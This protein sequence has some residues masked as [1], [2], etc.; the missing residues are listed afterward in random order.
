MVYKT[1]NKTYNIPDSEI[2]NLVT[3]LDISIS[4][5]VDLWLEDHNYQ[6]NKEQE[7]LDAAASKVK[8]NLGNGAEDKK[9]RKG[10]P[11][12]V[13]VSDEKKELFNQILA[14]LTTF[15]A[16]NVTVLN[17][18]KLFSV[19]IGEKTFKINITED[20]KQKKQ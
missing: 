13:K 19:K 8:I 2:D 9:T 15:Y 16:N 20:R 12:T 18:N 4:E 5:A 10:A 11:R 1:E 6:T 3:S 14:N 7:E 17:E